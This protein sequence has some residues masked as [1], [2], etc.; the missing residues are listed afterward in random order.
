MPQACL[1]SFQSVG[2]FKV[3]LN[4]AQATRQLVF[5]L[6]ILPERSVA[7]MLNYSMRRSTPKYVIHLVPSFSWCLQ[8]RGEWPLPSSAPPS[9][10]PES[11]AAIP[12]QDGRNKT[13]GAN[14]ECGWRRRGELLI[15]LY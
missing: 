10:M 2:T 14:A 4:G 11:Q 5:N 13:L 8:E 6:W 12:E 15:K 9:V 7:S 3:T 1:L